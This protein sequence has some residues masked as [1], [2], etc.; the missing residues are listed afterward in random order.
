MAIVQNGETVEAAHPV[1][2]G[3]QGGV[4]GAVKRL[5]TT[6]DFG[7]ARFFAPQ[8]VVFEIDHRHQSGGVLPRIQRCAIGRAVGIDD[9]AIEFG[10]HDRGIG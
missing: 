4:I 3:L 6:R 10:P 5:P 1:Q 2:F 8:W 7:V 9:I